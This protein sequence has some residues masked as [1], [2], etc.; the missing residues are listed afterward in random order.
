MFLSAS[1]YVV[2]LSC[3]HS[4]INSHVRRLPKEIKAID[5]MRRYRDQKCFV[6]LHTHLLGMGNADFWIGLLTKTIPDLVEIEQVDTWVETGN[7]FTVS[8]ES[9]Q[10]MEK[11][12]HNE[13]P[14]YMGLSVP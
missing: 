2:F 13:N 10:S 12:F 7:E 5:V 14:A 4:F 8:Q 9:L 1:Q 11:R 3:V 6:D